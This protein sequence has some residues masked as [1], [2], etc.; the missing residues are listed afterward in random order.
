MAG[1][2]GIRETECFLTSFNLSD[3]PYEA[4][5]AQYDSG[6]PVFIERNG[7]W[8]I[9]GISIL[10]LGSN[11]FTG[12]AMVEI[13]NYRDWIIDNIPNY[14][15][16]M[17]GLPDWYETQY[18]G[19][20]TSMV[21]TN[22]PDGDHLTNYEEWIADTDPTDGA[23]YLRILTYTEANEVVF[24]S[25]IERVYRIMSRTNLADTNE[26]WQPEGDWFV[27]AS[28]QTVQAVSSASDNRVFRLDVK[29]P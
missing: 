27:P 29:L 13:S 24:N 7:E 19:D 5:A 16:D 17:D 22:D 1:T 4:G 11:P 25:S 12:N 15:T 28:T 2:A 3:T 21:A 8:Y 18:G 23:S 26:T 9:A 14:D 10:L 20:P 6:G